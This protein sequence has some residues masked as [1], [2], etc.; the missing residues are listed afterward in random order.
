MPGYMNVLYLL[1]VFP[2]SSASFQPWRITSSPPGRRRSTR[3]STRPWHGPLAKAMCSNSATS[4]AACTSSRENRSDV[5]IVAT[6]TV[7]PR[8]RKRSAHRRSTSAGTRPLAGVRRQHC[9]DAAPLRSDRRDDWGND[10][11]S[12]EEDRARVRVD[13]EVRVPRAVTLNVCIGEQP[14][15]ACRGYR[16]PFTISNVNGGLELVNLRGSGSAHTP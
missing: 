2:Q 16:G 8:R 7:G 3:P 11:R 12:R 15:A 9:V 13:F 14:H 4:T 5:S 6:R 10:G 1:V